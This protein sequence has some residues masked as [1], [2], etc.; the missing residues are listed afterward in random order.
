M[1]RYVCNIVPMYKTYIE[2]KHENLD[3]LGQP[4]ISY[5]GYLLTHPR[6]SRDST[7]RNGKTW[8]YWLFCCCYRH[9]RSVNSLCQITECLLFFRISTEPPKCLLDHHI[10]GHT[11]HWSHPYSSVSAC[12][13]AAVRGTA[14]PTGRTY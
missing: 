3:R 4:E 13:T 5:A 12:R 10:F 2:T 9:G 14:V 7:P 11:H 8:C 1:T 6:K